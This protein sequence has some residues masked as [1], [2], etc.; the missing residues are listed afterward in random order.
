M[1]EV[2]EEPWVTVT[3]DAVRPNEPASVAV[4]VSATVCGDPVTLSAMLMVAVRLPKVVGV[5]VTTMLQLEE[6]ATA[7]PQLLVC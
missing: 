3:A 7:V 1:V 5:K 2:C 6:D 4:P